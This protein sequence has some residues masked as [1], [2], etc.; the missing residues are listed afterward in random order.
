M[1]KGRYCIAVGP[2]VATKIGTKLELVFKGGKKVPA[3]VADQKAGTIDG[4][5]HPDG[6]AVEFVVDNK[7]L[8]RCAKRAGDMSALK[9][10][11]GRIIKIRV[12]KK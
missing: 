3:V 7:A 9:L 2:K 11:K 4:Y 6:S 8:P 1:V 10:F 5:R 12:Y